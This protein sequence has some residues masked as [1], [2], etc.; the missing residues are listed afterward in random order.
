MKQVAPTCH[1]YEFYISRLDTH[2]L[3][4]DEKDAVVVRATRNTFSPQRKACF[5]RELATEGFIDDRHTWSNGTDSLNG[6]AWVIDKSWLKLHPTNTAISRRF[7]LHLFA[8][9]S[10]LWLALIMAALWR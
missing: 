9:A 3:V 1:Q 8:G 5:I 6:V 4:E 10:V 7:M 2:L